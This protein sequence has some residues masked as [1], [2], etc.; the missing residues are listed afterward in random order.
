MSS[1]FRNRE[2]M[3][4]KTAVYTGMVQCVLHASL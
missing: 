1:M 2:F 3:F 4:R